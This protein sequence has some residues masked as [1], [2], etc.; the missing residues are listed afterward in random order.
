MFG[1]IAE[2]LRLAENIM[3]SNLHQRIGNMPLLDSPISWGRIITKRIDV[4]QNGITNPQSKGNYTGFQLGSDFWQED[5][6]RL[7]AYFGYL[8]GN[9]TVNGFASGRNGQ[10]GKNGINSYFLGAYSTYMQDNG[11]YLD[12]VL[13]GARHR[14]D[15]KPNSNKNSKQ[16][17]YGLSASI[18][19]GKPFILSNKGWKFEPQAQIIHQWLDMHDSHISGNTKVKHSNNNA[20]LFRI[21]ARFEG[22]FKTDYTILRPYARVNLFYSPSGADHVTFASKN[23]ATEFSNGAKFLSSEMAIGGSFD[24]NN[25]FSAYTEIGHTWTNGGQARVKAPISASIGIRANW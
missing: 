23:T 20:W 24:I 8:Y 3:Q 14:V 7:G 9:L 5:N 11:T 1:A 17:S 15:V 18:E 19:T 22:N 13:Q 25:Q 10:V 21:G 6:W 2:Q 12:I 16:K 4:Q